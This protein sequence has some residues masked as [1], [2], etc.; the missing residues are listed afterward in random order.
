MYKCSHLL[1]LY[2]YSN[3]FY[4]CIVKFNRNL[5]LL[6][7]FIERGSATAVA[8]TKQQQQ[9]TAHNIRHLFGI[10]VVTTPAATKIK[11]KPWYLFRAS[12]IKAAN[13]GAKCDRVR[14]YFCQYTD[15]SRKHWD[16]RLSVRETLRCLNLDTHK[17]YGY[18]RVFSGVHKN[19]ANMRNILFYTV[20]TMH[21]AKAVK[22]ART[23]NDKLMKKP[24]KTKWKRAIFRCKQCYLSICVRCTYFE[25]EN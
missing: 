22:V 14:V 13:G 19:L 3:L 20:A 2:I 8:A 4:R 5:A 6:L 10:R 11:L 25:K 7:L 17:K 1:I 12:K 15:L 24:R 16:S 23:K 9:Q 18:F 21:S